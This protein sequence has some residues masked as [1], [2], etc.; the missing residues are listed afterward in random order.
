MNLA[1]LQIAEYRWGHRLPLRYYSPCWALR[2]KDPADRALSPL[3]DTTLPQV[4]ALACLDQEI[5]D[6]VRFSGQAA[7]VTQRSVLVGLLTLENIQ[8]AILTRLI[9][10]S[11]AALRPDLKVTELMTR[12]ASVPIIERAWMSLATIEDVL[13]IFSRSDATHLVVVDGAK[14]AI[15]AVS[16]WISRIE[17]LRRLDCR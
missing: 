10:R 1:W 6:L 17:M 5:E 14:Q 8:A 12:W 3:R 13:W 4:D 16:G 11:P 7:L 15:D 9:A 2:T